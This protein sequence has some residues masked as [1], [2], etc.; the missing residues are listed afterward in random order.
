MMQKRHLPPSERWGKVIIMTRAVLEKQR[1]VGSQNLQ[2]MMEG[3]PEHCG[4]PCQERSHT[5][6]LQM[7]R[8]RD[9]A[10]AVPA[11]QAIFLYSRHSSEKRGRE[12]SWH[13]SRQLGK[14]HPRIRV[15]I[16]RDCEKKISLSFQAKSGR[17]QRN[18]SLKGG[19]LCR[20]PPG[21]KAAF[22]SSPLLPRLFPASLN[23]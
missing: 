17:H 12:G 22:V 4:Y 15:A 18:L 2:G 10:L 20:F 11:K 16:R 1:C 23:P 14:S 5:T 3:D 19:E 6:G 7:R 8:E 13:W 9:L 21:L